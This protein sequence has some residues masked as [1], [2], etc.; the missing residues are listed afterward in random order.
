MS[1]LTKH[2]SAQNN[3]KKTTTMRIARGLENKPLSM[4]SKHGQ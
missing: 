3:N 4:N 2:E 1:I